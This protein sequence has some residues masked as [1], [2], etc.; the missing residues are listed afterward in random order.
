MA[1]TLIF[2]DDFTHL[3][4]FIIAG[5]IV[6]GAGVTSQHIPSEKVIPARLEIKRSPLPVAMERIE[7]PRP[8]AV[9]ETDIVDAE[10]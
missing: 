10:R 9:P 6:D 1:S 8:K 2:S 5:G 4:Q 7:K 3:S